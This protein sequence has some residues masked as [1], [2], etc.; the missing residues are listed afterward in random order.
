MNQETPDQAGRPDAI[1]NAAFGV[2]AAYG[3]RR[4]TMEDIA[5]AAGLSRTALYMH[6]RSKDDILRSLTLRHF[7]ECL[8]AM[9]L[10]LNAPG[11]SVEAALYAGFVAKDGKVMDIVLSTPHG[12]ELLDAGMSLTADLVRSAQERVA[13]LLCRWLEGRGLPEGL[14]PAQS[15]AQTIVA[16]LLGLKSNAKTLDDLRAGQRQLARLI[17][18]A[19]R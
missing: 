6:F 5:Q 18:Q 1:L 19:M 9:E 10:A 16:A 17:A 8:L 15:L 11:Q 3:Y 2:F 7:E 4:T 14:A 12:A 13:A